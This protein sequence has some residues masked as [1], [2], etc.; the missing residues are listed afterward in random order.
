ML[1]LKRTYV[2][3]Q[4]LYDGEIFLGKYFKLNDLP[5]ASVLDITA[6]FDKY[7]LAYV[8]MDFLWGRTV[9][10]GQSTA[11][12]NGSMLFHWVKDFT[13]V[14]NPGS[15]AKLMEYQ[16]VQTRVLDAEKPFSIKIKPR[17]SRQVK[18]IS[19]TGYSSGRGWVDCTDEDVDHY[20]IKGFFEPN[21][22][23]TAGSNFMGQL[24]IKY[25]YYIACRSTK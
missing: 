23:T 5:A 21:T 11:T 22:S 17:M 24:T 8:K 2:T 1:L 3:T 16:N 12:F 15:L 13:E 9:A 4:S 10:A 6:L 20:G 18:S 19:G 25:T 7:K 14:G